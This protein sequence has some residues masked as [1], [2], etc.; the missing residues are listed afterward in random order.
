MT[1]HAGIVP[2][3]CF[4][5]AVAA[6]LALDLHAGTPERPHTSGRLTTQG[7]VEPPPD[8]SLPVAALWSAVWIGVGLLFGL[9]VLALYGSDAMITYFTAYLLEKSLS[10]DN[11]FVFGV[12][13]G[14]LAIP[15]GYQRRVLHWG[16]IGALAMRAL[17]IGGGVYLL[18]RVQ[19][20]LYPFAALILLAAA[21]L[22]WGEQKER[23]VVV[24][25]CVVCGSWIS[26]FIPVTPV[27]DSGRFLV[28]QNG[29][30]TATPLLIALLVI[31]L[32][33]GV[34]AMDSIPSVLAVT[35]DPFLVYTSNVFAMLGLRSLYFLL[36][37]TVERLHMLRYAMAAMLV[38]VGIKLVLTG[39]IDIPSWTTL[40]AIVV[41][42]AI[43]MVVSLARP[44]HARIEGE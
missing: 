9:V 44:R 10:M 41:L 27:S 3:T 8:S 29:R 17:L 21:R 32:S 2:W 28:R 35:R 39:V 16:I 25:A 37:S 36:A 22:L 38:F 43:T 11:L 34:F 31:E 4:G 42:L 26:R 15:I 5:V 30:L 12:I 40:V 19:W 6:L 24:A 23:N 1:V 18:G 14:Q 33:D 13:F 7:T 20:V